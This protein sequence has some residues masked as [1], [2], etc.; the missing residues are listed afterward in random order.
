MTDTDQAYRVTAGEWHPIETA[1]R[2]GTPIDLWVQPYN[3]RC[4][5]RVDMWW[6][7]S[8]K[9]HGWRGGACHIGLNGLPVGDYIPSNHKVTHWM[10][11]PAPPEAK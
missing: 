2:D 5:R 7:K 6:L 1:P 9:W 3:G 11:L 8:Q 4:H 10:P